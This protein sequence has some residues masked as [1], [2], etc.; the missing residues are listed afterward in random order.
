MNIHI[1][2]HTCIV[3]IER[4]EVV[5]FTYKYCDHCDWKEQKYYG[6]VK[7]MRTKVMLKELKENMELVL[8]IF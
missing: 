1:N 5:N 4:G 3:G 8:P 2:L 6:W 7:K